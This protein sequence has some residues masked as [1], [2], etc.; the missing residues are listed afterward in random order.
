[1]RCRPEH[2]SGQHADG[3]AA[4]TV[5]EAHAGTSKP[6]EGIAAA[7]GRAETLELRARGTGAHAAAVGG[8]AQGAAGRI[9]ASQRGA[10]GKS[11]PLSR[12]KREGR[13]EESRGG[14]GARRTRREGRPAV[15]ELE[16][17]ERI[18]GEHVA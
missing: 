6:V 2:D 16:V 12:T 7:T 14:I 5:A 9:A 4:R 3:G 13:D 8:A 1:D 18:P 10:R 17:Q 15:A 11:Q